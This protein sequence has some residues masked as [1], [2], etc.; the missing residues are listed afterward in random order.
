MSGE[1][2]S[3]TKEFEQFCTTTSAHG[4]HYLATSSRSKRAVWIVILVFALGFG[5]FHLYTLITEYLKYE[6]HDSI[7]INNKDQPVFPDVTICDNTGFSDSS[8]QRYFSICLFTRERRF[9][10]VSL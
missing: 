2:E 3:L 8:L 7:V 9:E 10:H 4:F 6:Y 5:V 1:K